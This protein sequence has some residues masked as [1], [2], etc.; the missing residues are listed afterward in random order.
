MLAANV[1]AAA[2]SSVDGAGLSASVGEISERRPHG[3]SSEPALSHPASS[4]RPSSAQLEAACH[5]AEHSTPEETATAAESRHVEH[6]LSSQH[7]PDTDDT[8]TRHDVT[9]DTQCH[10]N[11]RY[12]SQLKVIG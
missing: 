10:S 5:S 1:A 8:D 6:P 7:P 12:T 9:R 2:S 4:S 3:E 11:D